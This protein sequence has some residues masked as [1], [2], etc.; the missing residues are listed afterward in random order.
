[1]M[2]DRFKLMSFTFIGLALFFSAA[3][4]LTPNV[5]PANTYEW[6][7]LTAEEKEPFYMVSLV[8]LLASGYCYKN[9]K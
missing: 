5:P 9:S 6:M 8:F 3:A 7:Y 4:Y 2:Q 1:M